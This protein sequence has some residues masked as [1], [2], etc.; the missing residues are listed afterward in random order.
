MKKAPKFLLAFDKEFER[1]FI[2][3]TQAPLLIAEVIN[4]QNMECISIVP[5]EYDPKRLAGLMNRM[6]DWYYNYKKEKGHDN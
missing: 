3:H 6:G 1:K 5:G 2:V 4:E